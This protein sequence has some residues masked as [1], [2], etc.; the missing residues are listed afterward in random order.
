MLLRFN[1]IELATRG[2]DGIVPALPASDG[3]ATGI[4]D[5]FGADFFLGGVS[6]GTRDT[7]IAFLDVLGSPGDPGRRAAAAAVLLSSPEFL[8]H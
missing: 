2:V 4:V 5:A 6:D 3:T 7:A 8:V 1:V